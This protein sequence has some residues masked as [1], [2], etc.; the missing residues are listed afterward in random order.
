[1]SSAEEVERAVEGG[2]LQE[3]PAAP[4]AISG[5]LTEAK[6]VDKFLLNVQPGRK[7]RF[8]V[9]AR[10][11]GSPLDGVLVIRGE[12]GNQLAR[13]DDRPGMLDPGLDFTVPKNETKLIVEISDLLNQGGA[14]YI[15][16]I[17]V[18]DLGRP[19]FGLTL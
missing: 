16:R 15:Y 13:N 4:V 2:A 8:D 17:D 12:K 14:K 6:Q 18:R 10:R 11:L 1:M 19:D 7:L 3:L 9:I 5:R